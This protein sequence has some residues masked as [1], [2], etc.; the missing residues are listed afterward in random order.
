MIPG[1]TNQ[2]L[3]EQNQSHHWEAGHL[4]AKVDWVRHHAWYWGTAQGQD[5][6]I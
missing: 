5:G 6:G 1:W 2:S 4:R 3:P